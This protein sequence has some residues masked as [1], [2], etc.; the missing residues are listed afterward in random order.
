MIDVLLPTLIPLYVI[1]AFGYIGGRYLD[2]HLHSMAIV[3]MY[4]I[5]PVVN[6]GAIWRLEFS[7]AYLLLPVMVYFV[8][9]GMA[10]LSYY[11]ARLRWKDDMANLCGMALGGANTGYFGLPIILALF[12]PDS[13][14]IYLLAT[15]AMTLSENTVCYY[16]GARGGASV[17]DSVKKVLGL[18][19]FHAIWAALALNFLDV[20]PPKAFLTYWQYF[21]GSW[22]VIGMM[23]IGVALAGVKSFRINWP[24]IGFTFFMKFII[25]PLAM[26]GIIA[27]DVCALHLFTHEIHIMLLIAG[28]VPLMANT[29]AF[30]ARLGVRPG[31]AATAV[32]LST[33]FAL[34]YIP[35]VFWVLKIGG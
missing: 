26:G 4:F 1:I 34:F 15:F 6:F 18:P 3:S 2:V 14:G 32:L 35:A 25:W 17:Q 5:S 19:A 11:L 13:A 8:A 30:A 12:G 29:V 16:I 20:D 22:V 10:F 28:V 33:L 24:L 31:E 23:L 21:A 27:L 9:A 7:P